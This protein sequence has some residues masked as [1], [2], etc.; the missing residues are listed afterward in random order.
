MT[1]AENIL[2]KDFTTFRV[3][4]P[5]RFFCA[6]QNEKELV[7]AITFS[8][9]EKIPFFILGGGSNILVSDEGFPG[10]VIKMEIK[11]MDFL[12]EKVTVS[13]GEDWDFFVDECVKR[14]LFGLENLSFIPGT[15]GAAPV[16]N[17]GAYGTEAKDVIDIVRVYD[18]KEERFI[19]F[20]NIDCHFAYRDSIFKKEGGRFI[21][22]SVV[23][24]LKAE[25]EVNILYR[26]LKEF[27]KEKENPSLGEVRNAVIEIRKRKL[28]DVKEIGSAGSFFKNPILP[29][30]QAY[31]LKAKYPDL[32][33]Y[34]V[35]DELIKVSLAWI[36]D[37]VCGYKGVRIG[38]V[39]TYK[40]QAL[41]LVNEGDATAREVKKVAE[42][43]MEEVKEKTGIEI[44]PEVQYI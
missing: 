8:K 18:T 38:N 26:D 31:E 25:G 36:L 9:K 2:L 6:V 43:M 39:G 41:V 23:F 12:G 34:P 29:V 22:T 19:D 44:E 30:A 14:N 4:G 28:P 11:G 42:K 7:E 40:N 27:F 17:I 15:V 13:A 10:L 35:N 5:A 3:G 32:P 21:I 33:L 1:F 16:Q 37:H 20:S 24:I